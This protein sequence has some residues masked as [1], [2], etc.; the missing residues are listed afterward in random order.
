M[1]TEEDTNSDI[2]LRK[3]SEVGEISARLLE[4]SL[5]GLKERKGDEASDDEVNEG[6]KESSFEQGEK[7]VEKGRLYK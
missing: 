6:E 7:A 1:D 4:S 5:E 3:G 2:Q